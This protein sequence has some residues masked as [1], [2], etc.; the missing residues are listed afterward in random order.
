MRILALA[1]LL[2]TS[3]VMAAVPYYGTKGRDI[4]KEPE[5]NAQSEKIV[6]PAAPPPPPEE[7]AGFSLI[8]S[9]GIRSTHYMQPGLVDLTQTG[10]VLQVTFEVPEIFNRI[11]IWGNG[12]YML[13]FSLQSSLSSTSPTFMRGSLFAGYPLL[14]PSVPLQITFSGGGFYQ[15]YQLSHTSLTGP[16][17]YSSFGAMIFPVFSFDVT[18]RDR[19]S[20]YPFFSSYGGFGSLSFSANR[21]IGVNLT[22]AKSLR[23]G[24]LLLFMA[25]FSELRLNQTFAAQ[26]KA[27]GMQL[28][29]GYGW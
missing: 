2:T 5:K 24:K 13:P 28:Q 26:A 15:K 6:K 9:I 21:E 12:Q 11:L 17:G 20:I 7:D 23:S 8:P 4:P 14:G 22:W 10:A 1:T 27:P 25:E 29:F 19:I 16:A 18:G 3:S